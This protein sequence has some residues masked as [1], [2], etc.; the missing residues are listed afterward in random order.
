MKS[1][2]RVPPVWLM[3]LSL[4]LRAS[5]NAGRRGRQAGDQ[6]SATRSAVL[7]LELRNLDLE[8]LQGG[9]NVP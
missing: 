4:L 6:G 5:R 8:R 1:N 2:R 7:L 9:R 3:G